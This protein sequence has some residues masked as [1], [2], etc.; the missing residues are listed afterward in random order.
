M[1]TIQAEPCND[2]SLVNGATQDLPLILLSGDNTRTASLLHRALCDDG[3]RV[4]F[5]APYAE[6]ESLWRHRRPSM[7]LLEVSG[8]HSVEAAVS[9][10]LKLKRLDPLQFV[11]YVADP[12][13]HTSG[14]AGDAIY[15]RSSEELAK[16]LRNHFRDDW[17]RESIS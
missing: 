9:E 1:N 12:A 17:P 16:A 7:V 15:P 14:L 11:G 8:A 4:Q 3:F 2:I 10:A 6:L 13:L 5:A